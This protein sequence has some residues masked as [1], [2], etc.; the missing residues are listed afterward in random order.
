[1]KTLYKIT[2][3]DVVSIHN[4]NSHL[5]SR[6]V[7]EIFDKEIAWQKCRG[8]EYQLFSKAVVIEASFSTFHFRNRDALQYSL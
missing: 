5:Y 7:I 2:S 1:M 8:T 6:F 4:Y 3:I